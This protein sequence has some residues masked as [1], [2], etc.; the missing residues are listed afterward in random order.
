[1]GLPPEQ[2][3]MQA[4]HDNMTLALAPLMTPS[5]S[6]NGA[7]NPACFIHTDFYFNQPLINGAF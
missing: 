1:M 6:R 3:Y 5:N 4:W 7:F 2:A